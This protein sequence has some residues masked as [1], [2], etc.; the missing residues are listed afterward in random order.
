MF[1][2]GEPRKLVDAMLPCAA[3]QAAAVNRAITV[4]VEGMYQRRDA[5]R[6]P[7][8]AS[9]APPY[10]VELTMSLLFNQYSRQYQGRADYLVPLVHL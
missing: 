9:A 3:V 10:D 2:Q 7:H 8:N 6:D 4:D 5:L 1:C